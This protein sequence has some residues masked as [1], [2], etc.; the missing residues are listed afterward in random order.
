MTIPAGPGLGR[1]TC[2]AS[3]RKPHPVALPARQR[4]PAG[5][6]RADD[7]PREVL[8]SAHPHLGRDRRRLR[9]AEP[10]HDDE[11]HPS[12]SRRR[13]A[14]AGNRRCVTCCRS[15]PW[16][17]PWACMSAAGTRTTSGPSGAAT[18]SGPWLRSSSWCV[19][20][21]SSAARSPTPGRKPGHLQAR[22]VLPAPTRRSPGTALHRAVDV[23]PLPGL[24]PRPLIIRCISS[25]F[26]E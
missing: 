15:T 6:A 23:V 25:R 21:V 22:R 18:R 20:R 16:R 10:L 26:T 12:G 13:G 17:S 7:A 8:W 3:Q 14:H 2:P 4:Q 11:L 1:G 9:R 19:S 5:D 24:V